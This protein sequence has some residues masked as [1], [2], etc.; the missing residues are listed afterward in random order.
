MLPLEYNDN[1][2][3]QMNVAGSSKFVNMVSNGKNF[4]NILCD[5]LKEKYPAKHIGKQ[6]KVGKKIGV[7]KKYIVDFLIDGKI[8]VSAKSQD[9]MGTAEQKIP[10][11]L[12]NL[13]HLCE[14]YGYEKAYIVYS[15][16]GF[17]LME[18]YKSPEMSKYIIAPNVK[19]LSFE[20][21]KEEKIDS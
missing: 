14:T 16:T 11:E 13:Q 18:S 17:T 10:H 20:E 12:V 21:F 1:E 5:F 7:D 19:I 4:E 15:G 9:I 8:L 3:I 2:I 6:I